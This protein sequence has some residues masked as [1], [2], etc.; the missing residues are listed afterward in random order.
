MLAEWDLFRVA[1]SST[2][3]DF[4]VTGLVL[5]CIT[6]LVK[7]IVHKDRDSSRD[8]IL[9]LLIFSAPFFKLTGF[10]LVPFRLLIFYYSKN[11]QKNLYY[12]I[13][14]ILTGFIPFGIKNYIQTGYPFYP[15]VVLNISKPDWQ[16]PIEMLS[17]FNKYIFLSNHYINQSISGFASSNGSS[18]S[19]YKD[20]FL[21]LV[22]ADQLWFISSVLSLPLGWIQL[23]KIYTKDFKKVLALYTLSLLA[24]VIWLIAS[25][26]PRFIFG[27]L[28]FV[29]LFSLAAILTKIFS[30]RLQ[31]ISVLAM[32]V[33]ILSYGSVKAFKQFTLN[34]FLQPTSA[35]IPPYEVIMINKQTYHIPLKNSNNWNLRCINAPLPAF[36]NL[37]PIC[38]REE[39]S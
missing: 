33:A 34:N 28:L 24:I 39:T 12:S 11:K 19:L 22:K 36:M 14:I 10:F 21:H 16:V 7:K 35:D 15:Y 38:S 3:Y 27:F 32:T 31:A 17:L 13:L 25:P 23:K 20:W 29:V 4:V 9:L 37:I 6:L 2:S 30:T 5:I 1:S 18:F 26:D 8:T